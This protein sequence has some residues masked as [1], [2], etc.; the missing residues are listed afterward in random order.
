VT[1]SGSQAILATAMR[2]TDAIEAYFVDMRREGRIRS[3]K[4]EIAY[5]QVLRAHADDVGNRDPRTVGRAD[6][7]RTLAR[8]K[9]PNT[10]SKRH[11]IL[12]SFYDWV[13]Q[14]AIRDTNPARQVRR[15]KY[16]PTGKC[17][18]TRQ[19]AEAFLRAALTTR[20]RRIA[21]L[22]VL[23]GLRNAEL[24]G[25]QG[26]HFQR[27]GFV[28]I[29]ADIA[30]GKRERW[31]PVLG[32]LEPIIE[33]ICQTVAW[34]HYILP[35]GSAGGWGPY[36]FQ[37]EDP[38]RPMSSQTVQRTVH[39]S[40]AAPASRRTSIG[41]CSDTRSRITSPGP[42]GS[43]RRRRCSVTPTFRPPSSTSVSRRWRSWPTPSRS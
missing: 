15:A 40:R 21:Y 32:E 25:L 38:T 13:M 10:Q 14:E 6:I 39:A 22:G 4:S 16:A 27:P 2:M 30:K 9:N 5:R 42:S 34:E 28:H 11:A 17:R 18:L 1:A 29:S 36:T 31:I 43:N 24:R 8:W 35:R 26:R 23:A 3:D 7:K 19:G 33:D 12:A 41:I 37:R 20:E